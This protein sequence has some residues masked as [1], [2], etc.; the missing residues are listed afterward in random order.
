M[1]EGFV[2]ADAASSPADHHGEF[3]LIV[4]RG[5]FRWLPDRFTV[6]EQTRREPPENFGIDRLFESAFLEVIIVVETDTEDFRWL[7][8]RRQ[9]PNGV[10]VDGVRAQK[11]SACAQQIRA[12][13]NQFGKGARKSAVALVKAI[14]ARAVIGGNSGNATLLEMDHAH[15]FL[16]QWSADTCQ[17]HG[18]GLARSR[19]VAWGGIFL[20]LIWMPLYSCAADANQ[21][22][23][24]WLQITLAPK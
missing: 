2:A 24:S 18:F 4:Q 20:V 3:R 12:L 23:I 11:L 6:S 1:I 10:Q 17:R 16:L 13:R 5:R 21:C 22:C 7:R 8:H 19:S 9:Y 15:G 14:P